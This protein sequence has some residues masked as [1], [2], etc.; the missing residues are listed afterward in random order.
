MLS[1]VTMHTAPEGGLVEKI[2]NGF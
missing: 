2:T 1:C